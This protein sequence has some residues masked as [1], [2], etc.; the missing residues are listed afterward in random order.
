VNIEGLP[1][2]PNNRTIIIKTHRSYSVVDDVTGMTQ[3]SGVATAVNSVPIDAELNALVFEESQGH[4]F[5]E[6]MKFGNTKAHQEN[7]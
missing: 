6:T 7:A 3:F 2:S 5:Q 4:D 1:P